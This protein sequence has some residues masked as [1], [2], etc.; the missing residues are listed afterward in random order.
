METQEL[1][2]Y[3]CSKQRKIYRECYNITAISKTCKKGS[4]Y[5]I[6][7]VLTESV[8]LHSVGA[9][10]SNIKALCLLSH[11]L[12]I[13]IA[14]HG[15]ILAADLDQIQQL[16]CLCMGTLTHLQ[17]VRSCLGRFDLPVGSGTTLA[18]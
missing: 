7:F 10:S 3:L 17:L 11:S 2:I 6:H 12:V 5:A 18:L 8:R 9:I 1:L 14:L 4:K 15:Q 13:P 16:I